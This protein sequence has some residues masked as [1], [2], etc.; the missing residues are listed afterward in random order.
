LKRAKANTLRNFCPRAGKQ[1]IAEVFRIS[2]FF[3]VMHNR[4][5]EYTDLT[6]FFDPAGNAIVQEFSPSSPSKKVRIS[7]KT[8]DIIGLLP[9]FGWCP[10]ILPLLSKW[11]GSKAD[12]CQS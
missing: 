10:F 1:V 8:S 11:Q 12:F 2:Q 7:F 3:T 6:G 4:V 5:C 9:F